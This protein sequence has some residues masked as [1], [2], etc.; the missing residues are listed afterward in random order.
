MLCWYT[1][2][3]LNYPEKKIVVILNNNKKHE[4]FV[5]YNINHFMSFT[6]KD[7]LLNLAI[8]RHEFN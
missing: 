8:L 3:F 7:S 2:S 1:Q 4:K 5:V 6:F